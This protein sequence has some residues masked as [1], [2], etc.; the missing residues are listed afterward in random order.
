LQDD[1]RKLL[2]VPQERR[3]TVF[4][5]DDPAHAGAVGDECR[6]ERD[7]AAVKRS[8]QYRYR[9]TR[10][11]TLRCARRTEALLAATAAMIPLDIPIKAIAC[12]RRCLL[13]MVDRQ[14]GGPAFLSPI[15]IRTSR[16]T[17]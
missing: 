6:S 5:A 11:T 1:A 8:P 16:R 4:E 3:Q 7:L 17:A 14:R 12:P 2:L 9:S 15:R 13:T 10:R